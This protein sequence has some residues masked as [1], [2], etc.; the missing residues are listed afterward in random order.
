[1]SR[2]TLHPPQTLLLTQ[3][4]KHKPLPQPTL[5]FPPRLLH[6]SAHP[7]PVALFQGRTRYY[8]PCGRRG[9]FGEGDGGFDDGVEPV[10]SVG[11]D[12]WVSGGHFGNIVRWVEVVPFD[13]GVVGIVG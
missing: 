10:P 9:R 13:E 7:I 8:D 1:M 4:T 12:E 3:I 2:P 5:A 6:P 11:V